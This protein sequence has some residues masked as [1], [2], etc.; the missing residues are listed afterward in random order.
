[1]NFDVRKLSSAARLVYASEVIE[2]ARVAGT[3]PVYLCYRAGELV[4]MPGRP[5][6]SHGH[7]FLKLCK[8]D[9]EKGLVSKRWNNL[10]ENM[11]TY[12]KEIS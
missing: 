12:F 1:M 3:S 10:Q 11:D 6:P 4:I 7:V 8:T 5:M 9:L 2:T